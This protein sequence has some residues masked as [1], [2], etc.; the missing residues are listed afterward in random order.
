MALRRDARLSAYLAAELTVDNTRRLEKLLGRPVTETEIYLSHVFGVTAAARFL[1]AVEST[2]DMIGAWMFPK[3]AKANPGIFK[4]SGKLATL[5]EIRK[6]F[7]A[8]MARIDLPD[9]LA[10]VDS[11]V[12]AQEATVDQNAELVQVADW[13]DRKGGE[14]IA[15]SAV[16]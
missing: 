7:T 5:G 2:P 10:T 8:K 3:A 1:R 15:A 16:R 6:R 11:L 9:P 14:Q 12:P 13:R 4:I